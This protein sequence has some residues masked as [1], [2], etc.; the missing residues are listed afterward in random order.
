[1]NMNF[2][3]EMAAK[4]EVLQKAAIFEKKPVIL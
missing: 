4:D 2:S 3:E 1:L